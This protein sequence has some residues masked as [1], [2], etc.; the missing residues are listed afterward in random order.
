MVQG[1]EGGPARRGP[2][3]FRA[4]VRGPAEGGSTSEWS[5]AVSA[6]PSL[7]TPFRRGDP[8]RKGGFRVGP[9][10]SPISDPLPLTGSRTTE[11]PRYG[12]VGSSGGTGRVEWRRQQARRPGSVAHP[13]P[14]GPRPRSDRHP[15]R[16]DRSREDRP[17]SP[18]PLRERQVFVEKEVLRQTRHLP[19]PSI[20]PFRTVREVGT[21]GLGGVFT[22]EPSTELPFL[23]L[24]RYTC[25][26]VRTHS[27]T[28][29]CS[30]ARVT[31]SK[32]TSVYTQ[33]LPFFPS[34][35]CTHMDTNCVR[36][37]V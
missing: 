32:W 23:L 19:P 30:H 29:V 16:K 7:P 34:R 2:E 27:N 5:V 6:V 25:T 31:P 17:Q 9:P 8:M 11:G 26:H 15:Y 36:E 35:M 33:R 28:R 22:G 1:G 24:H 20:L 3:T 10:P 37:C 12:R 13:C 14:P 21:S 4:E 18:H